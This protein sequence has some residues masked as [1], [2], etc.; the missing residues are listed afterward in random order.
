MNKQAA[1]NNQQQF[2]LYAQ[3][4]DLLYQDK[5]YDKETKY[6][7]SLI[8]EYAPNAKTILSLG[9]GTGE[10]ELRISKLGYNV[11]G[12]DIS[13][14]MIDIAKN[15]ENQNCS[16]MR[17]DI[18]TTRLDKKFDVVI[19]LFH[20]MSYQT[21]NKDLLSAFKTA[22]IHLKKEGIFL[23][24]FWYGPAVLADKPMVRV[25]RL[26]NKTLNLVRIA[27]P[28]I[29]ENE[30]TVDIKYQVI[31]RQTKTNKIEEIIELHKM[32]YFFLPELELMLSQNEFKILG[33]LKWL[34]QNENISKKSWYGIII[35]N[36]T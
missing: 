34:E 32:R 27:E 21:T 9:C 31:I 13:Q 23:F 19:S 10:Y 11:T 33:R 24:D 2:N 30:N 18:R 26:K 25:K 1:N 28:D 36:K 14:Q 5:D 29:N 7:Q 17:G 6:V 8:Q 16:F 35:S 12:V 20:V 4:Y 15:K 22:N 3:Y